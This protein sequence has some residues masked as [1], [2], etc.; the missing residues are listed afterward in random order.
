MVLY[1]LDTIYAWRRW[2]WCCAFCRRK[3]TVFFYFALNVSM[4]SNQTVRPEKHYAISVLYVNLIP[5]IIYSTSIRA[6]VKVKLLNLHIL[7]LSKFTY[8]PFG[9]VNNTQSTEITNKWEKMFYVF[10]I[11]L[12][13][14]HSTH[15]V[16]SIN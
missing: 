9:I 5:I 6:Y 8:Q 3:N 1:D 15:A 10:H 2:L 4:N 13:I 16:I 12:S 7:H 11:H 14:L